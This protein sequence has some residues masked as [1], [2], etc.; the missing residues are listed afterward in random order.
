MKKT[1]RKPVKRIKRICPNCGIE[2]MVRTTAKKAPC[3]ECA[4]DLVTMKKPSKK[5][6]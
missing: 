6:G 1:A 4:F 2:V 5:Q 3:E